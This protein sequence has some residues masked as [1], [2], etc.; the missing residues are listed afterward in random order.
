M[1]GLD[2]QGKFS[3]KAPDGIACASLAGVYANALQNN[4]PGQAL[5]PETVTTPL[6]SRALAILPRRPSRVPCPARAN[7][8][9]A[10]R[11]CDGYGWRPGRTT[12]KCCT[13]SRMS[14]SS[15]IPA[16]GSWPTRGAVPVKPIDRSCPQPLSPP[17]PRIPASV[18]L[19]GWSVRL[20]RRGISPSL[21]L[22]GRGLP[23]P[24]NTSEP[25]GMS[26]SDTLREAFLPE[27]SAHADRL[28]RRLLREI[29]RMPRLTGILPYVAWQDETRLFALDQG[30][31]GSTRSAGHRFF[32]LRSCRKPAPTTKWRRCWPASSSPA[33]RGPASRSPSTGAR[34]FSRSCGRR[35]IC[36]RE[37][38][39]QC[40]QSIIRAH[41]KIAV[42][43]TSSGCSRGGASTTTCT[44]PDSQFFRIRPIC[45]GIFG[46]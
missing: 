8:S 16:V 44:V 33:R 22:R 9:A 45:Y 46:G 7:Q 23:Q 37:S 11:Q 32:A 34:T 10:P 42:T 25:V 38:G 15:S 5:P 39:T 35:R 2:G 4:L 41:G 17:R 31:F 3:C 14:T 30:A 12:K 40:P 19:S 36:C 6:R 29:S 27:R 24:P 21:P 1:S 18:R 43:T 13:T 26:L 28:P 20:Q